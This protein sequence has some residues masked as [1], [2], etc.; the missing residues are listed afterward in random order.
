MTAGVTKGKFRSEQKGIH[1]R[2][3]VSIE[4]NNELE[5]IW[6]PKSYINRVRMAEHFISHHFN[7]LLA[8]I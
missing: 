1:C 4:Q 2:I 7:S 3:W 5:T 6:V 8:Q